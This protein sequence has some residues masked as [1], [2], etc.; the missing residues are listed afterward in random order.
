[1]SDYTEV[2]HYSTDHEKTACG[3]NIGPSAPGVYTDEHETVR[4]CR[5][6]LAAVTVCPGGCEST[7]ACSCYVAGYNTG[8]SISLGLRSL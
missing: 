3:R 4:G 2:I 1:M 7:P 5:E 6:C 8:L